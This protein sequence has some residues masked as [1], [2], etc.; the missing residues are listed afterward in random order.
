MTL[1]GKASMVEALSRFS[2]EFPNAE[3]SMLLNL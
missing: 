1:F 3:L 2:A